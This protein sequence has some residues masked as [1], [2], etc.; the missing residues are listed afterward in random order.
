MNKQ[1]KLTEEEIQSKI[2]ILVEKFEEILPLGYEVRL[3]SDNRTE[4]DKMV[5]A[6]CVFANGV[7]MVDKFNVHVTHSN[8][9]WYN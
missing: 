6:V 3:F 8:H 7:Q 5:Y 4:Q 2:G 1:N 9:V